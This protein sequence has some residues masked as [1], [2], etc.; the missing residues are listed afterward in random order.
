[1]L[2]VIAEICRRLQEN[3]SISHEALTYAEKAW[4]LCTSFHNHN[5]QASTGNLSKNKAC[6][7]GLIE[8]P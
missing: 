7:T 1:M 8:K 2:H 3:I 5:T 4:S 6:R